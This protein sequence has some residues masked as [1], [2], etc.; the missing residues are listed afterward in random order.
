MAKVTS[1]LQVTLPRR[2]AAQYG[3]EPGSDIEWQAAGEAIRVLPAGARSTVVDPATNRARRLA[4]FDAA[5]TRQE[6]RQR[7]RGPAKQAA[8]SKRDEG[9][10]GWTREELYDRGTTR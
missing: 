7:S 6:H 5:T 9:D 8:R 1:K 3:I 10:R 4:R 2:L